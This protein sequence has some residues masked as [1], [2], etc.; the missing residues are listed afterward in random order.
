[1]TG[2][3]PGVEVEVVAVVE[4]LVK[5]LSEVNGL[6]LVTLRFGAGVAEARISAELLGRMIMEGRK[7]A[8]HT[9]G[10]IW[11]E[12]DRGPDDLGKVKNRQTLSR[13]GDLNS[14]LPICLTQDF[15]LIQSV[16]VSRQPSQH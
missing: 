16:T 2:A 14:D 5:R 11:R 10:N 1:M 15:L 4:N 6:T 7:N 8:I 3:G 13:Y 9:T 12:P